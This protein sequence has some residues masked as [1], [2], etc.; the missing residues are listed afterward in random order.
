MELLPSRYDE[1][2]LINKNKLLLNGVLFNIISARLVEFPSN[3]TH[4][5][6]FNLN[7]S[8]TVLFVFFLAKKNRL[9]LS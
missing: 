4:F 2:L 3:T 8:T 1:R 9:I 5:Q 7:F 6:E